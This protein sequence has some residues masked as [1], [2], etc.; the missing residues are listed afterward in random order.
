MFLLTSFPQQ[1]R[2]F[3][4]IFAG[5]YGLITLRDLFRWAERYRRSSQKED[6]YDWE[7]Q[8]AEDGML[9][10]LIFLNLSEPHTGEL[11]FWFLSCSNCLLLHSVQIVQ[12]DYSILWCSY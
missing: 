4:G 7:Q 6:F 10:L 3:S 1:R 11:V 8:L 12:G 2:S 5:K 9:S